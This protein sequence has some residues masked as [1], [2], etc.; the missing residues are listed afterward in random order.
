MPI[1]E[2]VEMIY[3]EQFGMKC[4]HT[5]GAGRAGQYTIGEE[6]ELSY[7]TG[8]QMGLPPDDRSD[9]ARGFRVGYLLAAEGSEIP[10]RYL[11]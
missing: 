11:A 7:E 10:E 4:G 2:V 8:G 5:A 6:E 9:F 3:F 1:M